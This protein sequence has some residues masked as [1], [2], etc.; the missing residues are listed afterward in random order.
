MK[1][2]SY[3]KARAGTQILA[4]LLLFGFP[5]A[6]SVDRCRHILL[7]AESLLLETAAGSTLSIAPGLLEIDWGSGLQATPFF[8]QKAWNQP[9]GKEMSGLPSVAAKMFMKS[10]GISKSSW[11]EVTQDSLSKQSQTISWLLESKPFKVCLGSTG[12]HSFNIL[13]QPPGRSPYLTIH[14]GLSALPFLP[15]LFVTLFLLPSLCPSLLSRKV[16]SQTSKEQR[17]ALF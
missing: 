12:Q 17:D 5:A 4:P 8:Y 10:S 7:S 14:F 13:H 16:P 2:K 3:L 6:C 9:L 1:K 11:E 15:L